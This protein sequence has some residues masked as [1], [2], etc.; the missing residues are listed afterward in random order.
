MVSKELLT[1][2]KILIGLGFVNEIT[3]SL[4]VLFKEWMRLLA[5]K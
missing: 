4:N 2:P 1:Y 3:E 5:L